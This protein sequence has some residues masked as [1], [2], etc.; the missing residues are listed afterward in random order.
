MCWLIVKIQHKSHFSMDKVWLELWCISG[1]HF[2]NS[3][4]HFITIHLNRRK[5]PFTCICH[6]RASLSVKPTIVAF[7]RKSFSI[8]LPPIILPALECPFF[9]LKSIFSPNDQKAPHNYLPNYNIISKLIRRTLY[10]I[11]CVI[12]LIFQYLR[13]LCVYV[14]DISGNKK[15]ANLDG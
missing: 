5:V 4:N 13:C 15:P 14:I 12:S 6:N 9:K 8:C 2:I 3:D 7:I 1:H 10:A 11:A